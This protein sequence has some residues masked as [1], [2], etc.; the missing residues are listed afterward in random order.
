L[1]IGQANDKRWQKVVTAL[2]QNPEWQHNPSSSLEYQQLQ[3]EV[4][5][6]L[7]SDEKDG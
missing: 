2:R 7:T 3:T 6:W 1:A 5:D 4:I